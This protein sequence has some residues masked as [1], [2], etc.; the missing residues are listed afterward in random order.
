MMK[1]KF[2]AAML[3]S[4]TAAIAIHAP[5][6]QAQTQSDQQSYD[7]AAQDLGSALRLYSQV[8]GREVIAS[9]TLVSGKRGARVRG[10]LS[11]DAALSRLLSGT[12]LVAE[13]V[14]GALVIREGN[15]AA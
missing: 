13:L 10:R 6:A 5:A 15:G 14:D 3:A 11:P 8:S 7:I 12:G 2:L 4:S 1:Y 9:S